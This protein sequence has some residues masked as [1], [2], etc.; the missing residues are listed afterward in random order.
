MP[1]IRAMLFLSAVSAALP[2]AA[3]A[4]PQTWRFDPVHTQV[5]FSAAHEQF[6]HPWGRVRIADGWFR[7]DADDW[8]TARVDV[9]F[10]LSTLDLGDADWSDSVKS[11]RF[12]D[13]GQWPRAHYVGSNVERT[14]ERSGVIHGDLKLHGATVPVDVAFTLNGIGYDAYAFRQKAG[15]SATATLHRSQFGI[16][17]YPKVVGE[18][19]DLHI[20]VEGVREHGAAKPSS[21]PGRP[22]QP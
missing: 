1:R 22:E 2:A 20:E 9:V 15:F 19:I 5:W 17:R 10:D 13:V 3:L 6:S 14:G 11:S 16:T 12:L 7:F 4:A 21:A 8:S 18:D